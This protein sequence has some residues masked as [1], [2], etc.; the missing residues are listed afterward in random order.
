MA[1]LFE[2][3]LT[4]RPQTYPAKS[5]HLPFENLAGAAPPGVWNGP[6]RVEGT[7]VHSSFAQDVG[8]KPL[9]SRLA[10]PV[11]SSVVVFRRL[12]KR[13]HLVGGSQ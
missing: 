6:S 9:P 12:I 10:V 11:D 2:R 13:N 3:K 7:H 1:C 8:A 5:R 4:P